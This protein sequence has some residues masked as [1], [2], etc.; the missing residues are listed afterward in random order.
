[1]EITGKFNWQAPDIVPSFLMG[2]DA[3]LIDES[4]RDVR[5]GTMGYDKK[6]QT[7]YGSTTILAA[8]VDTLVRHLG[9]RVAGPRDLSRPEIMEMLRGKYYSDAP[10]FVV[11]SEQDEDCPRNNPLI[12]QI[13][14]EA[15][16]SEEKFPFMVSGFDVAPWPEEKNGIG[17]KIVPRDDF[18]VIHDERLG[19]RYNGRRFAR[20]D[21]SG[22]PVFDEGGSRRWYTRD[23][24]LSGFY[25]WPFLDLDTYSYDF[26]RSALDGRIILVSG[27][28]AWRI[29][30]K[31]LRRIFE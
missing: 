6:T 15:S 23:N 25:V 28:P 3:S 11:R 9:I 10:V 4:T 2:E 24:G 20:V 31:L 22:L 29:K 14:E 5:S 12:K 19:G 17:A 1:M 18:K 16:G 27:E 26:T 13:L 7:F 21:E 8:R 30:G